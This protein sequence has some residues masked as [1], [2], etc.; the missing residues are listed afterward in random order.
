MT[1]DDTI[2]EDLSDAI[3]VVSRHPSVGPATIE[4]IGPIVAAVFLAIRLDRLFWSDAGLS[5]ANSFERIGDALTTQFNTGIADMAD[6]ILD[7][8]KGSG[9]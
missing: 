5:V 4:A 9:E 7:H 6:Q 8:M 1:T 2:G 3:K